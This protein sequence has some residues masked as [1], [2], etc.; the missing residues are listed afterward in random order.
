[1]AALLG[2][3]LAFTATMCIDVAAQNARAVGAVGAV[4]VTCPER[5]GQCGGKKFVGRHGCCRPGDVCTR[6][7]EWY[8]QCRPAEAAARGG[9]GDPPA[10]QTERS[11]QS[12]ASPA[13]DIARRPPASKRTLE[14]DKA[15]SSFAA[16]EPTPPS[17]RASPFPSAASTALG[18]AVA[19]QQARR[20][21][22]ADGAMEWRESKEPTVV[23]AALWKYPIDRML[24]MS[25]AFYEIQRAGPLPANT[26]FPWRGDSLKRPGGGWLDGKYRG[27]YFD[28]GDHLKFQLPGAYTIARLAWLAHARR[29]ALQSTHFDG[30]PNDRWAREAVKWGAD[31][32]ATGTSPWRVLLHIGDISADH[33]YIGRGED[34]PADI[35]R[36]PVFCGRGECSDVAAETAAALAHAATV[37]ADEPRLRDAYWRKAG[38][39]Y[40]LIGAAE[41]MG[42]SSS[43]YTKLARYYKSSGTA[44]HALFAAAS[45]WTA[46]RAMR[47]ACKREA[48]YLRDVDALAV[49]EEADGDKKWFW[50]VPGWDNAWWDAAV[51]MASQGVDGPDLN[52]EPAFTSS[53]ARFAQKW[54]HGES[55]VTIS[56]AG[57]RWVSPWGSNR[58]AAAGAAVLLMWADLP[59]SVRASSQVSRHEARCAAVK[60]IHY[61]AGDNDRGGSFVAGFGASPPRRNH[62]RDS[63]C[64]P[65]EQA[66][67]GGEC[68]E[69]F[70]DVR[71]PNGDCPS[72]TSDGGGICFATASR[73][74]AFQTHGALVGGPKTPNDSGPADRV[75][76]S[77]EGWNDWRTD[78]I[79]NE[80]ALDYNAMFTIALAETAALPLSFWQTPCQHAHSDLALDQDPVV[81]SAPGAYGESYT[82]GDFEA[83][84]WTRSLP[85]DWRERV[86]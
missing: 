56:P 23:G 37:F 26:R 5:W 78:W 20:V 70:F 3:A 50:E 4:G 75:P 74:N 7:N 62:H 53:L 73:P 22:R 86:P 6:R 63:A 69:V 54:V 29:G 64:A 49:R 60:Q 18:N 27:G 39:A 31:F 52:G 12:I 47:P 51:L 55:P 36:K 83:Y 66:E 82:W 81:S 15:G 17:P 67:L 28:A 76:Y 79:G 2:I 72:G 13:K 46:C 11:E 43:H 33:S 8:S 57:Q 10:S 44:S 35:D 21:R 38:Q 85:A 61:I 24:G 68:D 40:A 84:G 58:Y 65:W 16:T 14:L 59:D 80:Q 1:M 34:Y 48:T 9:Y 25:F 45:M 77:R 19:R 41:A 71:N 42:A 30:A 32:L